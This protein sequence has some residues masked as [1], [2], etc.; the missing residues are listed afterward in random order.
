M[1][2]AAVFLPHDQLIAA[3][4]QQT[5]AIGQPGSVVRQ[6][7][8]DL[9]DIAAQVRDDPQRLLGRCLQMTV[10]DEL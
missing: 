6:N 4:S 5:M 2:V 3:G 1:R 8:G 9:A 10:N 7:V